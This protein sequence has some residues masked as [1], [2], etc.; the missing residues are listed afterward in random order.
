MPNTYNKIK[1]K[2]LQS[3]AEAMCI[4]AR[5]APKAKGVDNLVITIL[6]KPEITKVIQEMKR[7]AK[8]NNRPSCKRDAE[9]IK[10]VKHIVVIGTKK[11]TLGLDCGFCGY[12]TCLDLSKTKGICAYNSMDL[13]IALGSACKI[14]S[15]FNVDNRLMY[16]IGKA[17]INCK[18]LGTGIAQAIGIP[19]EA[20]GKNI[21]FD[22]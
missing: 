16:S 6:T 1:D 15:D 12:K 5:T 14:A 4:S 21:F 13:G 8:N 22:R 3:V 9:N 11:K 7:I 2:A 19:L 18:I 10:N 17:S 20:T